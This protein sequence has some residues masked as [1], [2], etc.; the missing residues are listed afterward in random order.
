MGSTVFFGG[1]RATSD[2]QVVE[3]SDGP[4]VAWLDDDSGIMNVYVAAYNGSSWAPF[5]SSDDTGSGVTKSSTPISQ[6]SLATDG[7]HVAIAW[8]QLIGRTSYIYLLEQ[9]GGTWAQVNNSASGSGV[10][11]SIA[12]A[13]QPSVAFDISSLYVAWQS[14][15][16]S[17]SNIS[18]ATASGGGWT[19]VSIT[20][21]GSTGHSANPVN[22]GQSSQPQLAAADGWLSLVWTEIRLAS[23]PNETTAIYAERLGS[24]GFA[25]QL[26]NDANFDGIGQTMSAVS[27]I[28]LAVDPSGHPFVAWGDDSSGTPQVY[29]R[30][31]TLN[32]NHIYYVNDSLSD[33]DSFTTAAGSSSNS[34]TS[35]SSPLNSVQAVLNEYML[36]PGDVVL[37][38]GGS[39][40]GFTVPSADNGFLILGSAGV[41][42]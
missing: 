10:S 22:F 16:A 37:V 23:S 15:S 30:G 8:T 25:P 27:S 29:V 11:G 20:A 36:G 19:P 12:S 4:V 40:S 33:S 1:F 21:P 2:P 9:T 17:G 31:D 42:A 14:T 18:A 24:S 13:A 41:P 7:T 3:T 35:P 38:D 5:E 6:Y 34:G 39:Y 26:P 32:V 28:V